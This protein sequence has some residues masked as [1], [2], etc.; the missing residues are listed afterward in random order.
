M[1]TTDAARRTPAGLCGTIVT[2][3][4]TTVRVDS[5]WGRVARG[6]SAAGFATVVAAVSH[7]LGGGAPPTAFAM[8]VSLVISATACTLL[9]GRSLSVWRLG[10]SV[11]ISQVLFHT[12][13]SGLGTPIAAAHAHTPAPLESIVGH[14]SSGMW[15]AHIFAGLITLAAL[16]YAETAFWGLA[17]TARLFFARLVAAVASPA[18]LPIV[19][20]RIALDA[21]ILP[22]GTA[23]FISP[24]RY[25]GPP[26]AAGA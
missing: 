2:K 13:F 16:R 26:V 11:A 10:A 1:C 22:R 9:A 12:L 23:R 8:L 18:P 5:R 25:R 4:V 21:A 14:H 3:G 6:W 20:H 7:T 19:R 17:A 24:M 15:L